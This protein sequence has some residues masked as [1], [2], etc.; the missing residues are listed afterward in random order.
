MYLSF[1]SLQEEYQ[2]IHEALQSYTK[3]C[4]NIYYNQWFCSYI[5]QYIFCMLTFF[6]LWLYI[7]IHY[8]YITFHILYRNGYAYM[9]AM[10]FRCFVYST[11][12]FFLLWIALP[13][14]FYSVQIRIV[15][16]ECFDIH[17]YE[18]ITIFTV[19]DINKDIWLILVIL[20][21]NMYII[22]ECQ[23]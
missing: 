13:Y 19:Y 2:L 11:N 4:E 15:F 6:T 18:Y 14:F 16:P 10:H 1:I 23:M 9:L 3:S 17:K 22:I 8:F 21:L 12:Y 20:S 5:W 7:K